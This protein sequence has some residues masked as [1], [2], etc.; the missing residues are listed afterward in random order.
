MKL[1]MTLVVMLFLAILQ[2][3]SRA[4]NAWMDRPLVEYPLWGGSTLDSSY[5]QDY[6]FVNFDLNYFQFFSKE[7]PNWSYFVEKMIQMKRQNQ[8]KINMY[9]AGGSHLQ[10]DI[11]THE[12]RTKLQSESEFLAGERNWIF[13][14]DLAGTNN[15]WNYEFT[16]PNKWERYRVVVREQANQ[17]YGLMGI[18][19]TTLDSISSMRFR[20]DKTKVKTP[21]QRIRIYHNK[22]AFPF[23]LD[24]HENNRW[25]KNQSSDTQIGFTEVEFSKAFESFEISFVRQTDEAYPLEIYGLQLLNENPGISYSNIGTNGAALYNYTSCNRLEEQLKVTP[26]DFFAFSVG[27]NDGNVAP[28]T[29]DPQVYKDNLETLMQTVLR[30]NPKCALLLTV[31]NDSYYLGVHTNPNIDKQRVVI[32]ELAKKYQCP[33]WDLYGIMGELGSAKKWYRYKLMRS[34]L[35]HFSKVGYYFKGDL[36]YDALCKAMHQF[37]QS[38]SANLNWK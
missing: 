15:P 31:P 18:K 21:I 29:F 10:A 38:S 37:E 5:Y 35:V 13:P 6:P 19:I 28:E 16:S 27:T 23:V 9:H 7:S 24:W 20:Y 33:V 2:L 36:Y 4:Q 8:G 22:G 26:P 32:K 25:V 30:T 11:Y 12:V 14:Y 1:R 34:D 17:D 3:E